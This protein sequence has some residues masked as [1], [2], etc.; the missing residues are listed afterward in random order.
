MLKCR[1]VCEK[2]HAY[3]DGDLTTW[4][5]LMVRLHVSMCKNCT[6]FIDQARKTKTILSKSLPNDL[7]TPMSPTLVAAFSKLKSES[8]GEQTTSEKA[9]IRRNSDDS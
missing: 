6:A 8:A 5:K 7:S 4:E 9:H 3:V 1:E 2:A